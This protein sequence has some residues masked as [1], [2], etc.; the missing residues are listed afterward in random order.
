MKQPEHPAKP[1]F[2]EAANNLYAWR[3]EQIALLSEQ[4]RQRFDAMHNEEEQKAKQI[5]KQQD[6]TRQ[7]RIEAE[8]RNHLL[9]K[10]HFILTRF[11]VRSSKI[12]KDAVAH[13]THTITS[14]DTLELEKLL[15][16]EQER[17]DQFLKE[18]EAERQPEKQRTGQS[19]SEYFT[20]LASRRDRER[21]RDD[22]G[23]EY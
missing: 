3:S 2:R 17:A 4:Q 13:A 22:G 7:Q 14:R 5:R 19:L 6:A 10:R 21:D 15:H 11:P 16:Q 12:V 18:I 8:T 1:A 20:R 23:R 9:S